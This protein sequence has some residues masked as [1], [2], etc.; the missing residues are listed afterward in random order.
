MP[1]ETIIQQFADFALKTR[2]EDLPPAIV[3]ET[4][5]ILMDSVGCALLASLTDKGKINLSLAKRFG[6]PPEASVIGSGYKVSLA[7]ATLVNGELMYTPDYISMIA[8]GNEPSYVLPSI[9]SMAESMGAS[10]KELILSTAI[11]LEI[12]TRLARATLRQTID[13]KEVQAK[14]V[15]HKLKRHGNAYSNFGAAAG[16]GRLAGLDR[17]QLAHALGIA[18]HLCIVMTHGRYGS[19]G[20]RWTLKYGAP[21]FQSVGAVSAVLYAQMGYTGDLTQLDDADN[22]FW[23]FAGYL[24]WYPKH[25][26]EELGKTWLYNYRMQYKPYP[27]CSVWHGLL[28][29]FTDII[30]EHKLAPE[31]I[32]SV[33]AYAMVPMDHPLYGNKALNEIADAQF[34]ARYLFSAAAHRVKIGIDWLDKDTLS[35]PSIR[36]FM[37]KV[38]WEEY[39]TPSCRDPKVVPARVEVTARGKKFSREKDNPHG[40]VGSE[41]AMSQDELVAK[42]RRNAAA[43][44]TQGQIDKAVQKFLGLE[45]LKDVG[46][47]MRDITR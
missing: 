33:K 44:L 34:N 16:A 17:H 31:D 14:P 24:D 19:A 12:S 11:G 5:M 43:A 3:Q 6:G 1:A 47:L 45:D 28:D 38:T 32:E 9:V 4:K 13:P 15:S 23:Y 26:T 2:F 36:G 8:S 10:G 42:F 30:E 46:H 21:G 22:G 7:T 20:Q 35:N 25:L 39:H 37:D 18:G 27:C 29:C 40:R 41:S